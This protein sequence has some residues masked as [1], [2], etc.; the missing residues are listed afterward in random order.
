M[1]V[2]R[3]EEALLD[4]RA[5]DAAGGFLEA[6]E[7]PDAVGLEV[8][9]GELGVMRLAG[10]AEVCEEPLERGALVAAGPDVEAAELGYGVGLQEEIMTQEWVRGKRGASRREREWS[11]PQLR[12]R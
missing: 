9:E 8:P 7:L 6:G 1:D 5:A 10:R 4:G 12:L 2:V 3:E 11:G